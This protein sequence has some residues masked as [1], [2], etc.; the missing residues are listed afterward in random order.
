MKRSKRIALILSLLMIVACGNP[1]SNPPESFRETDLIGI[2]EAHYAGWGVDRLILRADGRFKQIFSTKDYIFETP[3]NEWWIQRFPDGKIWV[4]LQGAR[5]YPEG[6]RIAELEGMHS[7]CPQELSRCPV[8]PKP[9]PFFDPIDRQPLKM[10]N[11]LVLN[12]QLNSDQIV[13][14]QMLL[15]GEQGAASLAGRA[16]EFHRVGI[17]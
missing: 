2:W 12:V 11:E 4:H 10:T 14:L 1:Y 15:S 7:D 9:R 5:Y 8:R 6:I 3:W 17:P 13:L 16:I